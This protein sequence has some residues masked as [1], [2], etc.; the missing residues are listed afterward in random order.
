MYA[1]DDIAREI[2]RMMYWKRDVTIKNPILHNDGPKTESKWVEWG[3][4]SVYV[5]LA[6]VNIVVFISDS[7]TTPCVDPFVR[8]NNGNV[9]R[10]TS[11]EAVCIDNENNTA[12]S[13]YTQINGILS[14]YSWIRLSNNVVI[15]PTLTGYTGIGILDESVLA[16]GTA[17]S[18]EILAMSTTPIMFLNSNKGIV[19]GDTPYYMQSNS[20]TILGLPPGN[21]PNISSDMWNATSGFRFVDPV[22]GRVTY[23]D[24][25]CHARINN[26]CGILMR[27]SA[28][29]PGV[30]NME[31]L[32]IVG[33]VEDAMI[34]A[35]T[36]ATVLV[37][38]NIV[39]QT[40]TNIGYAQACNYSQDTDDI[41]DSVAN[42]YITVYSN[43][44]DTCGRYKALTNVKHAVIQDTPFSPLSTPNIATI[45]A[46][47]PS[48][49]CVIATVDSTYTY[50][51]LQLFLD[52]ACLT[53]YQTYT[54]PLG[55]CDVTSAE[56]AFM[57]T[58]V[59]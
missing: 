16:S 59:Y 39:V 34:T 17:L 19:I 2:A 5:I 55:V 33:I 31:G 12:C 1:G 15:Y 35:D 37:G 23:F 49:Q 27:Q 11:A 6:I 54:F 26:I 41:V 8:S 3:F 9:L 56:R 46:Y 57:W 40:I 25:V 48:V 45:L 4:I 42:L 21:T 43:S 13:Q 44:G 24:N 58:Y 51:S 47:D 30:F 50:I 18:T 53:D 38:G 22:T 14:V 10:V 29:S 20:I 36:G 28:I 7:N 32:I 52:M